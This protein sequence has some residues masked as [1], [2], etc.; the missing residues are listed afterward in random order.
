MVLIHISQWIVTTA[1]S[2]QK[3]AQQEE[4]K[5]SPQITRQFKNS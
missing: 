1:G 5:N 3:T 2:L 4:Q